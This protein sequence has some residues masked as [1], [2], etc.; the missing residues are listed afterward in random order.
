MKSITN[1]LNQ[2]VIFDDYQSIQWAKTDNNHYFKSFLIKLLQTNHLKLYLRTDDDGYYLQNYDPQWERSEMLKLKE[3]YDLAYNF[4]TN[5]VYQ[6]KTMRPDF[7]NKEFWTFDSNNK[8][9]MFT[10]NRHPNSFAYPETYY[11]SDQTKEII[12]SDGE[13]ILGLIVDRNWVD[14]DLFYQYLK[15]E[16][17]NHLD[18]IE[19]DLDYELISFQTY[20]KQVKKLQKQTKLAL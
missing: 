12:M 18:R 3:N 8:A 9:R 19:N 6:T 1:P 13:R 5:L 17:K 11:R 2:S 16:I 15:S 20:M 4:K 7:T 14:K 10:I